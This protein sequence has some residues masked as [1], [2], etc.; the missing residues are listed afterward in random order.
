MM[1]R[2]E[3][4]RNAIVFPDRRPRS[5]QAGLLANTHDELSHQQSY[6]QAHEQ[7]KGAFHGRLP[8]FVRWS[9]MSGTAGQGG[10]ASGSRRDER[11]VGGASV[12][13]GGQSAPVGGTRGLK[14][15]RMKNRRPVRDVPGIIH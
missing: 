4:S 7:S 6:R 13:G 14:A 1:F 2:P 12:R 5:P 8:S 9:S 10:G 11:H 15:I 3:G